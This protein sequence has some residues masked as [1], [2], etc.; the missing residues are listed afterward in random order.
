MRSHLFD[1]DLIPKFTDVN[2]A[3]FDWWCYS[4]VINSSRFR[5]RLVFVLQEVIKKLLLRYNRI[6]KNIY[7]LAHGAVRK[8]ITLDI[9]RLNIQFFSSKQIIINF[10]LLV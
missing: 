7:L 9:S 1:E 2:V 10:T 3:R 4:A 8:F 6:K 5:M